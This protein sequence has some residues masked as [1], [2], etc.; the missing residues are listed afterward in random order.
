M[1]LAGILG[2]RTTAEEVRFPRELIE[3]DHLMFSSLT[4]SDK[5]PGSMIAFDRLAPQGRTGACYAKDKE[6]QVVRAVKRGARLWGYEVLP[7]D[8]LSTSALSNCGPGF[9]INRTQK[10]RYRR[11]EVK[12]VAR[13]S[14]LTGVFGAE[15]YLVD[16][17][18]GCGHEKISGQE[19][20]QRAVED[21]GEF[22]GYVFQSCELDSAIATTIRL[23]KSS[24][25]PIYQVVRHQQ[26]AAVR[27][28]VSPGDL[29]PLLSE[30]IDEF[31][32]IALDF[33]KDGSPR[34]EIANIGSSRGLD[35]EGTKLIWFLND[36]I[37]LPAY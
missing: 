32:G 27:T 36:C 29:N 24:R 17:I 12:E 34:T 9:A 10:A 14:D 21:Y 2:C 30:L 33:A 37:D 23:L 26:L 8:S 20:V 16:N 7:K 25:L 28:S 1:L 11:L 4:I 31:D 6:R 15:C 19:F 18:I 35:D 13:K 22:G 5:V 3:R